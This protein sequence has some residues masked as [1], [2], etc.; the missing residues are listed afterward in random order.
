MMNVMLYGQCVVGTTPAL[1]TYANEDATSTF[2]IGSVKLVNSTMGFVFTNNASLVTSDQINDDHFAGEYGINI[3][4]ASGTATIYDNR[5]SGNIT[6]TGAVGGLKFRINDIDAGDHV[7]IRVFNEN[8]V[9]IPLVQNTNFSFFASTVVTYDSSIQEFFGASS[10][11]DNT[12][13]GSVDFNFSAL[14]VSRIE[15]D[16]YDNNGSGTVTFANFTVPCI[17][18][19]NDSYTTPA[20]TAAVT[21]SVLNNDTVNGATANTTNAT[22][23]AVNTLPAGFTFNTNGTIAVAST[24]AAGVYAIDYKICQSG[25]STNCV[26]ATAIITVNAPNDIDGDG[27]PNLSD[28]DDD[29]DGIPDST[30]CP[31]NNIVTNGTFTGNATGWTLNGGWTFDGTANNIYIDTDNISNIDVSQTLN[32]L[33]NTNNTI[34]VTMT[35]GARDGGNAA[36]FAANLQI[37][38][39][40]TLYA[41]INNSTTR[42]TSVNNVTI[43][44]SNGATSNFVPFTTANITGYTTTTFT[45]NIPNTSIP[46]SAALTFR[47]NAGL[48]DWT[49]DNVSV[50]AFTC[51]TDGDG[52]LNHL[53]LDSDAD[54]CFDAL[55]GDE[56]VTAAQLNA[57]GS[58][59][60]TVNANGVPNLVNSG[61]TADIGSDEGQG[62]G[63]SGDSTI[64]ACNDA[65]NDGLPDT[66][67]VDDDNDGILDTDECGSTERITGGVFPT[68]GGN[69][70]TVPGWTVDGTYAASGAWTSA[71]GRVNLGTDGLTFVR[72]NSTV[73][74]IKQNLT[75]VMR[76]S[77]ININ[78]LYWYRTTGPES[79]NAFTFTVSYGG[80]VYATI[81]STTTPT[82]TITASNGALVN[83]STLPTV[84]AQNAPSTK[85]NLVITLP[86]SIPVNGELALT[87][88]AGISTTSTRDLIMRSISLVS[89]K[90]TDG[91]GTPDYLD[92]DS[93]GDGCFDAIEGDE[94]V[95]AAQVNAQ[96]NITGTVNASGVP[97]LVN[98]GGAADIGSDQGQGIG[99]STD[100]TIN[101]CTDTDNDGIPDFVDLDDDNDGI[102][103]SVEMGSCTSPSVKKTV[104]LQNFGSL[105]SAGIGTTQLSGALGTSQLTFD[106]T[107]P[108]DEG[109][110]SLAT[111]SDLVDDFG[112]SFNNQWIH[113]NDHT[114]D[115]NGL[116]MVCNPNNTTSIIWQSPNIAVNIGAGLQANFWVLNLKDPSAAGFTLPNLRFEL[117]NATTNASLGF[118]NTGNIA[119]TGNW[120]NQIISLPANL[121]A[122]TVYIRITSAATT[123]NGN[124]FALDDI[125]ID[126]VYCDTDGDG[127]P[128]YL[129]LDSDGDGC[130]DVIEGGANFVSG[131]SYITNNSLNTPVSA[132]GIPGVPTAT[133]A[134]TGYSATTGQT[135]G[136]SVNN[137]INNCFCYK[138]PASPGGGNPNPVRHG[139]T[140]LNRADSGSS[141]WPVVRRSAWTV[142]ESKSKGFVVNR[143]AF[144]DADNNAATPTTPPLAAI[145][146]ANYVEGMMV[147]DTVA[148]CLKIYNGTVW[149]CYLTQTC[150]D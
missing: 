82:P 16:Y 144:V 96:G 68:T 115:T 14:K 15:F 33:R 114:V 80:V 45:L 36:G 56:N 10:S 78:Q 31:A 35:V 40:G 2:S 9:Q 149:N 110:Y 52:I 27:I 91:D 62:V 48:D 77:S 92:T 37:L 87:F 128:N 107:N 113:V 79:D 131:A 72:D 65:D 21:A 118:I 46:N 126:E 139:I 116:M 42:S 97:N 98:T 24:V 61:G 50:L 81:N 28:L 103:D 137:L 34:P 124:D 1:S 134:I 101:A 23:A 111:N 123:F 94:N 84:A 117:F 127:I 104:Y 99:Y 125:S 122:G 38:L 133:P 135:I 5:I 74:I 32:N 89:C 60:S 7:R 19:N 120:Q 150:P 18:A 147:Y 49:I 43:T 8:D 20:G 58:M 145:P 83:L 105:A 6:F 143:M 109:N 73:S 26:S 17:V 132:T 85:V 129:D 108:T 41:T 64:N 140:A 29:N 47:H 55:E 44:L 53:D 51:D 39:N 4:H 90:D 141:D 106:T 142:L 100:S 57:N 76:G 70:N 121:T 63:Y 13:N 30:E 3:A 102:L 54:G 138:N 93:D 119:Q 146:A 148:N 25:F 88:N 95:T 59:N 69:T 71:V 75:G 12:R 130:F 22:V 66:V 11:S 112:G 86:Y 136:D 67:D